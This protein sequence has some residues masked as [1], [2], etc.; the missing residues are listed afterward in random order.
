MHQNYKDTPLLKLSSFAPIAHG[1]VHDG[2]KAENEVQN[3]NISRTSVAEMLTDEAEGGFTEYNEI[4]KG[5][6]IAYTL[7]I[8]LNS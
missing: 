6:Y 3:L 4:K 7:P 5:I 1:R 2:S 8:S